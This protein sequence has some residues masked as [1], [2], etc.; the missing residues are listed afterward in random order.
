MWQAFGATS[1]THSNTRRFTPL[2]RILPTA[3]PH[4]FPIHVAASSLAPLT[5][6]LPTAPA[7]AEASVFVETTPGRAGEAGDG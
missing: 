4:G 2:T 1:P 5:R 6:I 7:F 3:R